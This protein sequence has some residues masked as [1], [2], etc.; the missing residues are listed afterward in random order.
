MNKRVSNPC[1]GSYFCELMLLVNVFLGLYEFALCLVL[2]YFYC[3]SLSFIISLSLS[4]NR[5]CWHEFCWLY[6]AFTDSYF[7]KCYNI[8]YC[9]TTFN[10][11]LVFLLVCHYL[12]V[13]YM[14]KLI[15]SARIKL[16]V[17]EINSYLGYEPTSLFYSLSY[18]Y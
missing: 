13:T 18:F 17:R 14:L 6:L 9:V 12:H 3:L 5:N 15:N 8:N 10:L 4:S 11:C 16:L 7:Y 1:F 2:F